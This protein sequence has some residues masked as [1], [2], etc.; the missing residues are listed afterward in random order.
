MVN[1]P[2]R[3]Q[4]GVMTSTICSTSRSIAS[5]GALL[6]ILTASGAAAQEPRRLTICVDVDVRFTE[7]HPAAT[8]VSALQRE[9]AAIWEPYGVRLEWPGSTNLEGCAPPQA[10]FV[11]LVNYDHG[12]RATAS[13]DQLGSTHL[14]PGVI[15]RAPICVDQETTERVLAMLTP[16]YDTY[17]AITGLITMPLF[18]ASTALMPFGAMPWWMRLVAG[19]N[20]VSY[21]IDAVRVIFL[22]SWARGIPGIAA[23]AVLTAVMAVACMHAFR[24]ATVS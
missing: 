9:A 22:D 23:V 2:R 24:R 8:L 12:E 7:R 6:V 1:V 3:P 20:P 14:I 19:L 18:F 11:V 10:S 5:L 17:S 21:A 13:V 4:I 16:D 15:D